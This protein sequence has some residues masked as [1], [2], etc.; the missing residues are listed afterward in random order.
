[1][2]AAA[3]TGLFGDLFDGYPT[4]KRGASNRCAYGALEFV[5]SHPK[6]LGF[7]SSFW[8]GHPDSC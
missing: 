3:P 5:R 2:F 1:M 6:A 8:M 4:L 7:A